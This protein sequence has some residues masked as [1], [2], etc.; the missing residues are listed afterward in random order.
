[1]TRREERILRLQVDLVELELVVMDLM[2]V[3]STIKNLKN[4]NNK[5]AGNKAGVDLKIITNRINKRDPELGMIVKANINVKNNKI[6]MIQNTIKKLTNKKKKGVSVLNPIEKH[7]LTLN[8]DPA[9][10]TKRDEGRSRKTNTKDLKS[11]KNKK[12]QKKRDIKNV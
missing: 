4:K 5:A 9:K 10:K 6:P 1:M 2:L 12:E 3:A 11:T 7:M 8:N